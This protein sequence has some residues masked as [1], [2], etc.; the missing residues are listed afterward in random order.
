VKQLPLLQENVL[1][2]ISKVQQ[3]KP[4]ITIIA[5]LLL[6]QL[7]QHTLVQLLSL[8]AAVQ[9]LPL[10]QDLTVIPAVRVAA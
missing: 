5:T 3:L 2:T 6:H 9:G 8:L 10:A 7:Q 4:L 1:E